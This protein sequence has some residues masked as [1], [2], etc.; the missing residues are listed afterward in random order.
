[1]LKAYCPIVY[2][3]HQT[4]YGALALSLL[5][6]NFLMQKSKQVL[7]CLG[8]FS[9]LNT[10]WIPG[11]R[12]CTFEVWGQD[13]THVKY[14]KLSQINFD[15]HTYIHKLNQNKWHLCSHLNSILGI[16][17]TL[18]GCLFISYVVSKLQNWHTHTLCCLFTKGQIISKRLLVSSDSS[19]KRTKEFGFFC[20]TLLKTNLFV[21]F[22][23]ESE[24]TKTSFRSYL[25]FK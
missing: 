20:L 17:R 14:F 23:E 19:K 12:I 18:R 21:R 25:T 6:C 2:T 4:L 10:Y 8:R 1:V 13:C 16:G 22:L 9:L 7:P 11:S 5:H 3:L 24:D 15:I